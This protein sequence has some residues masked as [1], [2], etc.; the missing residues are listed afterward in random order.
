MSI[1]G[2]NERGSFL[3]QT[4]VK[5]LHNGHLGDRRNWP[6]CEEVAVSGGVTPRGGYSHIWAI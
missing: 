2:I 6:D 3:F 1:Q 4:A 5:P